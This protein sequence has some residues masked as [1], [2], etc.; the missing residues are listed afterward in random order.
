MKIWFDRKKPGRHN[1]G[2][3][4]W[5]GWHDEETSTLEQAN[6]LFRSRAMMRSSSREPSH[7]AMQVTSKNSRKL[8]SP[9]R[10]KSVK[11]FMHGGGQDYVINFSSRDLS[12]VCMWLAWQCGLSLLL[13]RMW[14]NVIF[15][16]DCKLNCR[17]C[18][19]L[20]SS[21]S[22]HSIRHTLTYR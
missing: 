13:I 2:A 21:N 6:K 20:K 12:F 4:D 16:T 19:I 22:K 14:S 18:F 11:D 8:F 3:R 10:F 9:K 17:M 15:P 7:S 5:K 1:F